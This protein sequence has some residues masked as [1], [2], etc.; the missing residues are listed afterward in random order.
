MIKRVYV[1]EFPVRLVHWFWFFDVGVL[2]V[3]G[4]YIGL[5]FMYALRENELIM[6]NMRFVHF[7]GSYAFTAFFFIRIYWLFTG[8]QYAHWRAMV[9]ITRKQWRQ[10][11]DQSLFYA[12]LK[13]ESPRTIG[14][15]GLAALS[16]L[17]LFTLFGAEIIT[18][19]ALYSQSHTGAIW[20]FV[21]G[22][23]LSISNAGYIR[24]IHH[25]IMW[26]TFVFVGIHFYMG[27][28]D[29]IR[30][31]SGAKSSIFSGYKSVDEE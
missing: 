7:V 30:E 27:W 10:I 25:M 16:Y 1:W 23:L 4:L 2:S 19:F 31:K 18:G 24:L 15:T 26:L 3:T 20:W 12:F 9:P 17:G 11:G 14:H 8:N 5:P 22:W 6:S 13:K 21:G 28:Y 29:D